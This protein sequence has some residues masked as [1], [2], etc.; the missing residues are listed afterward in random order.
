MRDPQYGYK[1]SYPSNWWTRVLN[2][3]RYF[4]PWGAGG[5]QN[6]PYWVQLSVQPN[7]AG[8]T[9]AT[10]NN[11]LCGGAC[12]TVNDVWLKRNRQDAND[13]Y[14]EGYLFD[15]SYIYRLQLVVP[16]TTLDGLGDF[17]DRIAAGEQIFGTMSGRLA[18]ADASTRQVSAFGS[19]LFLKGSNPDQGSDLYLAAANGST[20]HRLTWDGGVKNYALSPNMESVAYAAT[21]KNQARRCMGQRD[22][23]DHDCPH[24]LVRCQHPAHHGHGCYPRPDL[25]QRSRVS[26]PRRKWRHSGPLQAQPPRNPRPETRPHT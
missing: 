15:A 5:T 24:Q 4:Y 16:L 8:L 18:L 9:A 17:Q 14:H 19:V 1:L 12:D 21:D 26:L 2:N 20:T 7:T 23:P 13:F 22:L 25:V 10:A 6:P 11:A 3:T